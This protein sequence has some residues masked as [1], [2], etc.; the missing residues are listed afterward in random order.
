MAGS[1]DSLV[2]SLAALV[3]V[4]LFT[5]ILLFIVGFFC[6]RLSSRKHKVAA[7]ETLEEVGHTQVFPPLNVLY[8]EVM[9]RDQEREVLLVG[10]KQ[11]EVYG[12]LR[13]QQQTASNSI[14]T[15][16]DS[17]AYIL[18]KKVCCI[19]LTMIC[20]KLGKGRP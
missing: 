2:S 7:N 18:R 13:P 12:P 5:S 20:G 17:Q 4:L 16:I 10:L 6:G 9:A 8:E 14:A 15:I 19:I 1:A 3:A 11:N